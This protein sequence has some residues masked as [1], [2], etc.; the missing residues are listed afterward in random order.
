[1]NAP[2][3]ALLLVLPL[4][5]VACDQL[6]G[7]MGKGDDAGAD[8]A[9]ATTAIAPPATATA[10]AA[11]ETA[12]PPTATAAPLTPP[13]PGV[14]PATPGVPAPGV[15]AGKPGDAGAPAPAGDAGAPGDAGVPAPRPTLTIP[16]AIPG[17]D[18]GAFKPPPGFP[19]AIPSGL[20]P[21]PPK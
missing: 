3:L 15:D 18:A 19:T 1:M 4:G 14:K 8:A 5:L 12:P 10:P 6:K 7:L 20:L 17:F 16:T 9:A 11:T 21:P 13:G 2:R